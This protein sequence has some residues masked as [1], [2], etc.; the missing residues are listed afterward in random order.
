MLSPSTVYHIYNI[1][2]GE[3]NLF[4]SDENYNF[5]LDKYFRYIDPIAETFAF[6]LMPNHFYLMVRIRSELE[7]TNNIKSEKIKKPEKILSNQF[8]RLF[9]SYSKAFN[10][11]YGRN[12]SLFQ[13][14]FKF[15]E[16]ENDSYFTQ[17][18][19]YIHNNPIKH[20]FVKN[21]YDWPYSSIHQLSKNNSDK[22]NY[23]EVID[24]FGDA[25][26]FKKVHERI[27]HLKSV[28]D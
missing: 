9:N 22:L 14:P 1:A 24:W 6:V 10:K 26:Q 11:M 5:F 25:D 19:L 4:R 8:G 13:R 23:S 17:L 15:K 28:F 2:N 7:I 3:D 20:G 12:G 21:I 16:V 18:I 27:E